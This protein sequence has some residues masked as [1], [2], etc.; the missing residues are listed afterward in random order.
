[1]AAPNI[2][3]ITSVV[4]FTT[5]VQISNS[6]NTV[7]LSNPNSSN[8]SMKI[9]TISVS[10][11]TGAL[12]NV[13]ILYF[14]NAAGAGTSTAYAIG[15]DIPAKSTLVVLDR[16]SSLYLEENR[17]LAAR[18]SAATALDIT[19]SYEVLSV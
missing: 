4:G 6:A 2:V 9:N 1:M 15:V 19:C 13:N 8:L 12:A 14:D 16:A 11:K 17:S 5:S 7:F 3:G 10:N 18:A